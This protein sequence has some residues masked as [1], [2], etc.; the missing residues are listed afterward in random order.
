MKSRSGILI[1]AQALD[2]PATDLVSR[3]AAAEPGRNG[4]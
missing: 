1:G 3:R 2:F 4:I